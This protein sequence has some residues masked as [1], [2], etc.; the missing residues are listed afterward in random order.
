MR[1]FT[2]VKLSSIDLNL[3]LVLHT[4]LEERS[5]TRAAKALHVT[6]PAI[7]NSLARLREALGDPLLVRSGRGLVPT[8]RALELAPQLKEAV[9]GLEQI[10]SGG[11]K[12]DPVSATRAFAVACTDVD[13]LSLMPAVA[14]AFAA[15]LP[16]ST[17]QIISVDHL[18]AA[19]GIERAEVDA[20][21]G[22]AGPPLPAGVH[23]APLYGDDGVLVLRRGHK[24]HR[25][26]LTREGFNALRH[27]DIR[28]ALGERG[29][30]N[31]MAEAFFE[32][33]GLVRDVA[34]AVPSFAAALMLAAATDL[35]AGVP[36]RIAKAFG[37]VLPIQIA[38]LPT[39][40]MRFAMLLQWHARTE[41]DAG[42][43]YFR[44]LILDA[45]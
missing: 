17:L 8:S 25:R 39:P 2:A 7:S 30:G 35:A 28:I 5:V 4:V 26:R 41:L 22:P 34:I 23:T 31:R 19:G 1:G 36:R 12:F 9:K 38:E 10:V 29:I 33:H 32:Q 18:E 27:I 15:K 40:P 21:L 13:Q 43:R 11:A 16:R 37:K 24:A 14:R 42:S 6:A 45:V 20:V 44:K 3:L